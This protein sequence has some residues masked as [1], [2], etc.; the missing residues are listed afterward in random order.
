MRVLLLI[1][2]NIFNKITLTKI[3]SRNARVKNKF[4]IQPNP[5]ILKIDKTW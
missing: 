1:T 4:T 2:P 5:P 3:I